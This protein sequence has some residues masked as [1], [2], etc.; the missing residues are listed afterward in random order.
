MSTHQPNILVSGS[1]G[2]GINRNNIDVDSMLQLTHLTKEPER[3]VYQERLFST[4]PYLGK[5][6]GNSNIEGTLLTG[7][8]N[9][10]RKSTDPNSE[11]S[12]ID[13]AYYPLLPSIEANMTNPA[14]FVEGA[15]AQG[16]VRGGLP[17]R[18]MNRDED[19][20]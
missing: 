10:N 6:P 2:G 17:S 13:Y 15:A 4:V 3:N 5:G 7:D 12:H 20:K 16:W 18:I 9:I 8:L 19:K 11:V 14:N 1:S